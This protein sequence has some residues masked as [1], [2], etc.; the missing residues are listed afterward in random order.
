MKL[1]TLRKIKTLQLT[2][3]TILILFFT[4]F[5]PAFGQD[6]S[7]YSRFGIGDI[8]P[9]T[10][11]NT[12][13]MGG[14]AAGYMDPLTINF[15]NPASFANFLVDKETK[16]NKINSGRAILDVGLNFEGRSL[17]DQNFTKR[18]NATNSLFSYVQIGIPIK[19][20][21][22]LSFG[23][24]PVSRISYKIRERELLKDP[25]TNMPID[26]AE[27]LY[28]GQ[29]GA[30]LVSLGTGIA[31]FKKTV[32]LKKGEHEGDSIG[33]TSL[34]IGLNGGY[35]FGEKDYSTKRTLFNDTVSYNQANYETKTN[36][37]SINFNAGIQY[38]IPLQ[39][40]LSL[41]LGAFG[42]W[43]QK[44][45]A[46]QDIIRETFVYNPDVGELRLDS[47]SDR[48]DIK[49]TILWPSSITAGFVLQKNPE[50]KK[51][52]GWLLGIDFEKQNW[53]NY[54]FYGQMDSVKNSWKLRIGGQLN[55]IPKRTYFS[56]VTYRF[57]LFFGPDYVKQGNKLNSVGGSVGLG[58][59]IA[60]NRQAPNQA[61]V[62]N[63]AF[64]YG[65]RG[66][67]NNLLSE[68]TFR[69]SVGL[70]LSDFWFIKRKYD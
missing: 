13:A 65:K 17:K 36:F 61:T 32:R 27:T 18:F 58:L 59:P 15:N 16:S 31:L 9:R 39:K 54:R 46:S 62:I 41:T 14:I 2:A 26:S 28:N 4:A 5:A 43:Q 30:Y 8:V 21:W 60:T 24:R 35:L 37:G 47:V 53:N 70:S 11:I 1:I 57:G 45:N 67:N 6:N 29:G 56:N 66:N 3:C 48:K 25:N 64:E 52:A 50:Y 34:S 55:P 40:R 44:I 49:G 68:N 12:R 63:V 33:V 51:S 22:G 19:P 69:I 42:N 38:K 7:P 20:K 23:L 10:N